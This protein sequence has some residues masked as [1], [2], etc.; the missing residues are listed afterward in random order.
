MAAWI[1]ALAL[2]APCAQDDTPARFAKALQKL[3]ADDYADREA[4]S[5]E[6]AALPGDALALVEAELKKDLDA[7]VRVR[8]DRARIALKAK[9][10][11]ASAERKREALHAFNTKTTADSYEKIGHKDPKWDVN[12]RAALPFVVQYW[13]YKSET[14]AART[15]YDLLTKA[16]EA[17]CDDP[18]VL[19]ARARTAESAGKLTNSVALHLDAANAMKERGAGY[20]P[21]RQ[22]MAFARL[23]ELIAG[24]KKGQTDADKQQAREWMD[25]AVAQLAK[26]AS[27]PETPESLLSEASKSIVS[28]EMK[29]GKDRKVGL[30]RVNEVL[31]KARPD[32]LLPLLLKGE[33]Y[34]DYA[35]D[36]RGKGWANTVTPEGW[37]LM[38]ERLAEAEEALTEAWK[39][40]PDDS[41]AP[42]QMLVVELGQGKGRAVMET[43]YQRAMAA[44]PNNLSACKKKLYYLEPKWYGDEEQMLKFARELVAGGNW[45]A[46]LPFELVVAHYTLAGYTENREDYYKKNPAVWKDL[47]SVY[48]PYLKRRPDSVFDHSFY[49]RYA[50]WCGQWKVAK[51]QFD[52]LGD[53]VLLKPFKDRAEMERLRAEAAE[54]GK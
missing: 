37:K 22:G 5:E 14:G 39:K 41:E 47:Q 27:D 33:V 28:T 46:R 17:G 7:E 3:G 32:S 30:D 2:L 34:T 15:A 1:L 38:A 10:K 54:K 8:L 52:L 45:D 20:H 16:V 29:L 23:A 4:A 49:A 31:K 25:L 19:Y 13:E 53:R 11:R 40:N 9:V 44:D 21:L 43:W 35:W 51:E 42:T 6:L 12:V 26:S 50:C 36:A 24:L 18:L 48:E